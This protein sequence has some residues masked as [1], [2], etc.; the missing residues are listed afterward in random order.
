MDLIFVLRIP[1]FF[2]VVALLIFALPAGLIVGAA[3]VAYLLWRWSNRRTRIAQDRRAAA[4]SVAVDE[5]P[6]AERYDWSN[7]EGRYAAPGAIP[8]TLPV[9]FMTEGE[10]RRRDNRTAEFGADLD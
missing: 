7:R 1:L 2:V 10:R 9:R 8:R 5:L 4:I 3:L 6:S